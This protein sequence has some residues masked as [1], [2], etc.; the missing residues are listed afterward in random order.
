[1][2]NVQWKALVPFKVSF[3]LIWGIGAL[4]PASF[5]NEINILKLEQLTYQVAICI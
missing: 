1:M 2:Q 3:P 4:S 5:P